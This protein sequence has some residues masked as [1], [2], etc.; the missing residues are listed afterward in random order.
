MNRF[1]SDLDVEFEMR[2]VTMTIG[3]EKKPRFLALQKWNK[4]RSFSIYE[5]RDDYR[6]IFG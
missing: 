4:A 3:D 5:Y 6:V 1:E 2:I